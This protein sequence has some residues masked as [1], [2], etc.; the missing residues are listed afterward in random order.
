MEHVWDY[1]RGNKLS[2]TVWDTYDAIVPGM[3]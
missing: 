2:P 3:R 1:L